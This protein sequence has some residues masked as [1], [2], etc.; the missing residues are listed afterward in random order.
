[1]GAGLRQATVFYKLASRPAATAA[2]SCALGCC[3][4]L[5]RRNPPA[6]V[7]GA[8]VRGDPV[9][10][11]PR[12]LGWRPK[13]GATGWAPRCEASPDHSTLS[14]GGP[15]PSPALWAPP[16]SQCGC[17]ADGGPAG[18]PAEQPHCPPS[19]P[20]G[21]RVREGRLWLLSAFTQQHPEVGRVRLREVRQPARRQRWSLNPQTVPDPAWPRSDPDGEVRPTLEE[22]CRSP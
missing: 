8:G 7:P 13:G 4:H 10:S 19:P 17:S 5:G 12:S 2:L 1:M 18:A 21:T 9:R 14:Q 6:P 22:L 20:A 16:E 3:L 15:Y 11:C